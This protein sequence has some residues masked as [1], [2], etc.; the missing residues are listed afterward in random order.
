MELE[1]GVAGERMAP[2]REPAAATVLTGKGMTEEGLKIS[3]WWTLIIMLF[4]AS[5]HEMYKKHLK[6]AEAKKRE[7]DEN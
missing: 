3:F 1:A 4:G 7:E 5:G 2:R 6:K